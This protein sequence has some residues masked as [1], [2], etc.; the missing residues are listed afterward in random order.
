MVKRAVKTP[1]IL[2]GGVSVTIFLAVSVYAFGPGHGHGH[3]SPGFGAFRLL[4]DLDL[5]S[6]QKSEIKAILDSYQ[7]EQDALH[8]RMRAARETFRNTV[9]AGNFDEQ[10]VREA[11]QTMNPVLEDMAVFH[12]RLRLELKSV[13]TPEQLETLEA[14]RDA[15]KEKHQDHRQF[16]RAVM[17][18][19]LTAD[20]E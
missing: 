7:D 18:A 8:E 4:M 13:L 15:F 2:L 20:A 12:T 11:Y 10:R 16:R 5:S 17:D 9:Q 3:G 14:R 19:W 6:N 1:W